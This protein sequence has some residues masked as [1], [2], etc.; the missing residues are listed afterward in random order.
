MVEPQRWMSTA[1]ARPA[2][3][4]PRCR[5]RSPPAL[6]MVIHSVMSFR[7]CQDMWDQALVLQAGAQQG[8]VTH[9]TSF[10]VLYPIAMCVLCKANSGVPCAC[11]ETDQE[12]L[13]DLL[14]VGSPKAVC[15][16][17]AA[18]HRIAEVAGDDAP[19]EKSAVEVE[20]ERAAA[21]AA[22]QAQRGARPQTKVSHKKLNQ[23]KVWLSLPLISASCVL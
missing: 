23:V 15:A 16:F 18:D 2:A 9:C 4:A 22:L 12:V 3:A 19:V 20:A 1:S 17:A 11:L 7:D 21:Q 13:L 5:R 10:E 6:Q 8:G 14:D